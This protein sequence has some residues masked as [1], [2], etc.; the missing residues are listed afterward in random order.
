M[1]SIQKT[2]TACPDLLKTFRVINVPLRVK[3]GWVTSFPEIIIFHVTVPFVFVTLVF[4][5]TNSS[6]A[7]IIMVEHDQ[8]HCKQS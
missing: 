3:Y 4:E 2:Y 5:N 1:S 8:S 7:H 6:T